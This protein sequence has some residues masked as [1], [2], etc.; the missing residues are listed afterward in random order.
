MDQDQSKINWQKPHHAYF[1]LGGKEEKDFFVTYVAEGLG[2]VVEGNPDFSVLETLVFGIEEAR[3]LSEWVIM[4]PFKGERK[5]K[6]IITNNITSESQNALLK[7]L[8]E[9]NSGS[10]IFFVIP[11]VGSLYKTL[12]SR[13]VVVSGL[14]EELK[15]DKNTDS[16][17]EEFLSQTVAGRINLIQK[18]QK[19]DNKEVMKN[20]VIEIEREFYKKLNYKDIKN[21]QDI[22]NIL[23]NSSRFISSRGASSKMILEQLSCLLPVV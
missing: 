8:E 16:L 13:V 7:V 5:I 2:F 1:L 9:P 15:K 12:L 21:K 18:L 4:K 20:L 10:Y 23:N 6:I 14:K 19:N 17:S 22:L 11:S 3:R